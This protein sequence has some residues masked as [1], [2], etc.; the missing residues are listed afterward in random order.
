MKNYFDSVGNLFEIL[1]HTHTYFIL[2]NF[3]KLITSLASSILFQNCLYF[4]RLSHLYVARLHLRLRWLFEIVFFLV[5]KFFL[6]LHKGIMQSYRPAGSLF[7]YLS[8]T[9]ISTHTHKTISR[10]YERVSDSWC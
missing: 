8:H 10:W 7:L 3:C 1:R 6:I 5:S 2:K 9:H 4:H